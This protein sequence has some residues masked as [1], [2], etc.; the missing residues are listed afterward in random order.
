[1]G[2]NKAG[3]I[4]KA[5]AIIVVGHIPIFFILPIASASYDPIGEDDERDAAAKVVS[6]NGTNHVGKN[7]AGRVDWIFLFPGLLS[8]GDQDIESINFAAFSQLKNVTLI[9]CILPEIT[10]RSLAHLEKVPGGLQSLTLSSPWVT[11][12]GVARLLRKQPALSQALFFGTQISDMAL[13]E[14]GKL[15]S[16]ERLGLSNLKLTDRG[17]QD[18][19]ELNA[20]QSLDL[21]GTKISDKAMADIAAL[22]RLRVLSLSGSQ[23]KNTCLSEFR[24]LTRLHYLT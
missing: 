12:A 15:S 5:L 22:Q 3:P 4:A 21:H 13:S 6:I 23:Y 9:T 1:M 14:I 10:D 2:A 11:D 20:L 24:K 8:R 19:I 16:L 7:S 18:L 17:L